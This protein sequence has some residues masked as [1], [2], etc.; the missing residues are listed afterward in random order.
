MSDTSTNRFTATG[1]AAEMAAFTPNPGTPTPTPAQGYTFFN[2]DDSTLYAWDGANWV[3]AVAA[4]GN[5]STGATLTADQVIIG[6][7][8]TDV[9]VLAAG[10]DGDVLTI[11]TGVPTWQAPSGGGG[12]VLLEQHT[13]SASASLDF[14]TC[15]SSTYD[16]YL[17][18]LVNIVPATNTQQLRMRM[19]TNAGVSYDSGNNYNWARWGFDSGG[20]STSGGSAVAFIQLGSQGVSNTASSGGAIGSLRLQPSTG[21][22]Q[23]G[24]IGDLSFYTTGA[25][26]F[27]KESIMGRYTPSTAVNAFQFFFASGNIASGTI[28]VYGLEK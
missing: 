14:T 7:G 13:A 8:T 16:D 25:S 6:A 26:S 2:T 1:T 12:L 5:V 21:S 18:E 20:G 28:R 11:V 23:T 19:S 9:D 17:I 24:V 10:T 3:P 27:T 22:N 4:A 15:I